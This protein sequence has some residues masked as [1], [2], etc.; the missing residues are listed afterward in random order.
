MFPSIETLFIWSLLLMRLLEN[1]RVIL[2][3]LIP[4]RKTT[5]TSFTRQKLDHSFAPRSLAKAYFRF[6]NVWTFT[7]KVYFP[8][9]LK[10]LTLTTKIIIKNKNHCYSALFVT[11][12]KIP[13]TKFN[14]KKKII[15]FKKHLGIFTNFI[16]SCNALLENLIMNMIESHYCDYK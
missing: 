13:I 1:S 7:I 6:R 9:K 2:L 11:C 3:T 14:I 5:F 15:S 8:L 12:L 10:N 4:D 16:I